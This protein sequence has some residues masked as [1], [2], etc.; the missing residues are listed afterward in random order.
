[1]LGKL[2]WSAI[3]FGEPI[4]LVTGIVLVFGISAVL[5]LISFMNVRREVS[6]SPSSFISAAPSWNSRSSQAWEAG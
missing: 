3:P 4:P 6:S 1:M 2:N 5:A